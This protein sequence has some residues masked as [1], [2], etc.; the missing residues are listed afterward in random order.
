V[1]VVVLEWTAVLHDPTRLTARLNRRARVLVE[2][3]VER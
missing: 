1:A 2:T 3:A